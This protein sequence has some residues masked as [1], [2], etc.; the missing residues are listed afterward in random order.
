MGNEKIHIYELASDLVRLKII[1]PKN[2]TAEEL[3]LIQRILDK[4]R[5]SGK[6]GLKKF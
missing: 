2:Y 5:I 1:D 3:A 6:I 4:L